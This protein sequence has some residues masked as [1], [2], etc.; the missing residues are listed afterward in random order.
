MKYI[1]IIEYQAIELNFHYSQATSKCTIYY[2]RRKR[3]HEQKC[4]KQSF[5]PQNQSSESIKAIFTFGNFLF[6]TILFGYFLL[7]QNFLA[8]ENKGLGLPEEPATPT[9]KATPHHHNPK[10]L[11]GTPKSVG[12]GA[13]ARPHPS[14]PDGRNP[15]HHPT[16]SGGSPGS[17]AALRSPQMIQFGKF[18]IS[19]WYSSPYPQ[20]RHQAISTIQV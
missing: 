14:K 12:S 10:A 1:M 19:T 16:A 6:V 2:L 9:P 5:L 7:F 20:V 17:L 4:K 11:A 3:K 8:E 18:D 15:P 13:N